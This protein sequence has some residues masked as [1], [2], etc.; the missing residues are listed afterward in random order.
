M[1]RIFV[2]PKGYKRNKKGTIRVN[3]IDI[4]ALKKFLKEKEL[5]EKEHGS[6]K[7]LHFP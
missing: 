1:K 5:L 6:D 3:K 4:K 2:L 7:K